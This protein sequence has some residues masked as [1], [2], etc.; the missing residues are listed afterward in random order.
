MKK[1]AS[2][3]TTI[4]PFCKVCY[5][6]GKPME[7]YTSHYVKD[8]PGVSGK[9]ICPTLLA[10]ECRYCRKKGHTISKCP[11]LQKHGKNGKSRFVPRTNK[12]DSQTN[13]TKQETKVAKKENKHLNQFS[14]LSLED[15]DE[16]D[17]TDLIPEVAEKTPESIFLGPRTP[18]GP[19][20][21]LPQSYNNWYVSSCSDEE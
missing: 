2:V 21:P 12:F 6:T 3:S 14:V 5:D 17:S 10:T 7:I 1:E 4:K 13:S 19:P 11:L 18:P 16:L 8:V 20:P 9:V 15:P